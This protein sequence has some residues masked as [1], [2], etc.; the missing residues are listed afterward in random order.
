MFLLPVVYQPKFVASSTII[1][2]WSEEDRVHSFA[3]GTSTNPDVGGHLAD[4]CA[5]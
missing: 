3:A 2:T 1:S 4:L 5:G